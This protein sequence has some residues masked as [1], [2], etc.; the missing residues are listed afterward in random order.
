VGFESRGSAEAVTG[1]ERV[2]PNNRGK[3]K[4]SDFCQKKEG[5]RLRKFRWEGKGKVPTLLEAHRED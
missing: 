3:E 4:C 2:L 5:I 1:L